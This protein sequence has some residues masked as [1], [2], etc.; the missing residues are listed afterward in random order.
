MH[1][2]PQSDVRV[3]R[4]LARCVGE[5]ASTEPNR[6]RTANWNRL[7]ALDVDVPPQVLVHLWPLAWKEALPESQLRCTGERARAYERDLRQRIWSAENLL[8][9]GVT[10]AVVHRAPT[11][12]LEPYEGLAVRKRWADEPE[13]GAAAFVPV[14]V[15]KRDIEKL[16]APVLH[17]DPGHGS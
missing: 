6:Q 8:D 13:M 14:I 4:D 5:I 1:A 3:L 7:N 16:G 12:W 2:T 11:A 17:H 9:D 15:E 10:E